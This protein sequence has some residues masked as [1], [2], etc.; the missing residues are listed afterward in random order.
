[1][2]RYLTVLVPAIATAWLP[3]IAVHAADATPRP[4]SEVAVGPLAQPQPAAAR[5]DSPAGIHLESRLSGLKVNGEASAVSPPSDEP[6]YGLVAPVAVPSP[7][8]SDFRP[9][10][11]NGEAPSSLRPEDYSYGF[12]SR[13][14]RESGLRLSAPAGTT[15]AG[16]ELSGRVGPLRWLS[17]LDGEG[18]TKLRLGGRAPGQP[19]MPG[20]GLF[21]VGIH[22]NFE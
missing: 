10:P 21:N 20:M 7:R 17:P 6:R 13:A 1:M 11:V 15:K 22:Y 2:R 18:E 16:W 9:G 19:R 5:Q 12:S 14:A 8:A 4:R 3:V